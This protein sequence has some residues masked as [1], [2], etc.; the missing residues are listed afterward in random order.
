M[1]AKLQR[2]QLSV[3]STGDS[4]RKP[5][6]SSPARPAAKPQILLRIDENDG[7][8]STTFARD[9]AE[10][11]ARSKASA[12]SSRSMRTRGWAAPNETRLLRTAAGACAIYRGWLGETQCLGEH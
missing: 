8:P 9:P 3:A 2:G 12:K 4:S 7:A 6:P 1:G 10:V 5:V 11:V